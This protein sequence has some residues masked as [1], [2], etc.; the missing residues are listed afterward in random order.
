MASFRPRAER[1]N[2]A[3]L[4]FMGGTR[5]GEDGASRASTDL[6]TPL[7]RVLDAMGCLGLHLQLPWH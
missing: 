7:L 6:C 3:P 1:Q 4:E 5:E 2:R